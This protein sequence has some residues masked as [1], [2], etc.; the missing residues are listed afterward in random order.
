[1]GNFFLL[2]A[3][4]TLGFYIGLM[5]LIIPAIVLSYAWSMAL[6]LLVDKGITPMQALHES[7]KLTYGHKLNIFLIQLIIAIAFL[8]LWF[9]GSLGINSGPITILLSS[10]IVIMLY[11]PI[12]LGVMAM[13]YKTL[14]GTSE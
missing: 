13:I 8:V 1:M 11:Y 3:M 4:M 7:N 14:C 12:Q 5:F 6:L 10:L 9:I 2:M